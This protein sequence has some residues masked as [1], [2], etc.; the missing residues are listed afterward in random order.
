MRLCCILG[1]LFC[2]S[3]AM[4]T[5]AGWL[6]RMMDIDSGAGDSPAVSKPRPK[7]L[8]ATPIVLTA[9]A[10]VPAALPAQGVAS[11]FVVALPASMPWNE[12]ASVIVASLPA[13]MPWADRAAVLV[14]TLPASM[15]W[16]DRATVIVAVLPA[17]MPWADRAAVIVAALP[18][19]MPWSDR[20]A[21]LVATLPASMP[22]A[23]RAAVLVAVLPASMPWNDRAAALVAAMP[24]QQPIGQETHSVM[25]DPF[26]TLDDTHIWSVGV[27]GQLQRK[28]I[29][30]RNRGDDATYQTLLKQYWDIFSASQVRRESLKRKPISGALRAIN[31]VTNC[32]QKGTSP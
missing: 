27:L 1:V 26:V 18:P 3:F 9:P 17:S 7:L 5:H 12:K 16:A 11:P 22:W 19:A 15:P 10:T 6:S 30:A 4:P 25:S 31:P 21:V 2:L 28:I 32:T 14:A 8:P 29:A 13:S 23:D 24:I 20:A